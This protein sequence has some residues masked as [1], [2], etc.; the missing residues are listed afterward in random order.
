MITYQEALEKIADACELL[1]VEEIP[2][3]QSHRETLAEDVFLLEDLPL[4]DNSAM[5][6]YVLRASDIR[7]ASEKK[8]VILV[9]QG[10]IGAGEASQLSVGAGT[11]L[12]IMTG[13]LIPPDGDSVV[14]VEKTLSE[15]N[16]VAFGE[17]AEPG[18]CIRRRGEEMKAGER[19]VEKGN[20]I[21]SVVWGL[22]AT[23]NKASVPVYQKPKVALLVTGD[24]LVEPGE[25]MKP[26]S[27]RN[28]NGFSMLGAL[29][30]LGV[31]TID[32]GVG[33]DDRADLEKRLEEGSRADVLITVGGV[34][35]GD[36]DHIR[37]LLAEGF[38][39]FK[40]SFYKVQIRPGKPV[41]FGTM[42]KT[43][44]FGLPGNP[45]SC[46]VGFHLFVK[47]ALRKM[48]GFRE[49]ENPVYRAILEEDIHS[50]AP[51]LNFWRGK[52][53]PKGG[54]GEWRVVPKQ[55]AGSGMLTT[56]LDA[57]CFVPVPIEKDR[58]V[59]GDTVD[60]IP[61]GGF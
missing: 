57:N 24:E 16:R 28:S 56:F 29:R 39:G 12:K 7:H 43:L 10:V 9:C 14:P 34:S 59:R 36:F 47:P 32:L 3:R 30:E 18:D 55:K 44:V 48:W 54:S 1:P 15:A 49:W 35:A 41:R 42:G 26:G 46:L 51:V 22:L 45:V 25:P 31:E 40:E 19:L 20:L 52:V 13:A 38:L 11:C 58:L 21:D 6:G 33:R 37:D 5:D 8:P 61:L 23:A 2:L 27:I 53:S 50:P 60:V 17:P 4:F